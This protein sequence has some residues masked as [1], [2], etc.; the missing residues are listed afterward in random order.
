MLHEIEIRRARMEKIRTRM[1]DGSLVE[2]SEAELR[3]DLEEGTQHAATA[4]EINSLTQDELDHLCDIFKTR[5]KFT[6]VEMGQEIVLS[7]DAGTLKI[8]RVG[9]STGRLHALQIYEK[10]L[11]ADTMELAHVDY[12]F[13]PVKPIVGN[14]Q[15]ALEQAL[16]VTTVPLFYG[17]MPNLGLYTQP[18]G[19]APNPA[20][21]L[22][23]GKISEARAA[24][25]QTIEHAVRD[26]VYVA[27]AMHESGADGINFDTT[28]AAGDPDFLA[29]L[30]ACEMLKK[31]YPEMCIEVG[32]AGEF[33][34]G[35][36]GEL[37]YQ[38]VR[39]AGLYPHQQVKLAEKAGVTIFGP[40]AN[41]N[42]SKSSPWNISRAITF[43][44]ACGEAAQIPIHV[45]MGMGVGA[46]PV[47][48][49]PPIDVVSRAS[50]AMTEIVR[51][52][53]L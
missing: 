52:D 13:K 15:P 11:G 46:V 20:E 30:Q 33:I 10:L 38:G 19:P 36:H 51:L 50:K 7:Y 40:V 45:N 27:S 24:H 2:L 35:M 5:A 42:T 34:L 48:D 28:G 31:K 8:R 17:A 32:M 14:E 18:D 26:M 44:K 29:T 37:S 49:H 4:A 9:V 23:M 47:A 53:G 6:S 41:T 12:S 3:K 43:M 16:L 39:L 22:P 1:G 25:E 21:L